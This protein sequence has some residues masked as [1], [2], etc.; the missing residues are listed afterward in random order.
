MVFAQVVVTV[1]VHSRTVPV[2]GLH[3]NINILCQLLLWMQ[4]N[5][6]S[7]IFAGVN[8]LKKYFHGK[9]HNRNERVKSVIWTRIPRTVF[10]RLDTLK[11]GV[12]DAVLCF[13]DEAAKRN[14]VLTVLGL[15]SD[16]NQ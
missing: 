12:H 1:D 11:F 14:I 2:Q 13:N 9:T 10:V 15:K 5:Q 3:M 16:S 4:L 7:G 6:C 8:S